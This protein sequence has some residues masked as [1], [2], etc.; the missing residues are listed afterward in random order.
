MVVFLD[1]VLVKGVRGEFFFRNFSLRVMIFKVPVVVGSGGFYQV[2]LGSVWISSGWAFIANIS[3]VPGSAC[4]GIAAGL[5]LA[6]LGYVAYFSTAEA[7]DILAETSGGSF[8][9]VSPL[10]SS[11]LDDW[12][13]IT[14][15]VVNVSNAEG[16]ILDSLG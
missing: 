7:S 12:F 10:G 15:S 9:V 4:L 5:S 16:Q 2:D 1:P 8:W 6:V 14:G 11:V 13:P 3:V